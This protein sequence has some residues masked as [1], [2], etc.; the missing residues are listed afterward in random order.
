MQTQFQ[1]ML[2]KYCMLTM[3]AIQNKNDSVSLQIVHVYG[4]V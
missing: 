4:R 2:S 3:Y 1:C